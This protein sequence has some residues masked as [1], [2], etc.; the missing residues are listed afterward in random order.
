MSAT[1]RWIPSRRWLFL[2]PILIGLLGVALLA[3][4]R[5]ELNRVPIE[6][7]AIPLRVMRAMNT[8]VSPTATGYGTARPLRVWTAVAEVGGRIVDTHTDL[9]SG[10]FVKAG[11]PLLKIDDQDYLLRQITKNY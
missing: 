6:E 2:P 8:E 1:H 9:R 11:E 10:V 4:S 7:A 5:K 3:M